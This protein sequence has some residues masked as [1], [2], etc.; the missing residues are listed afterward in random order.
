MTASRPPLSF[1]ADFEPDHGHAVPVFDG[2]MRLTAPN[3]GAFTFHGT[4][5]YLIGER[6]LVIIDPGPEDDTHFLALMNAIAGRPVSHILITHT[7]ADHSPLAKRLKLST[8][9]LT[10][11]YGP[12]VSARRLVEGEIN[13]LDASADKNFMPDVVV[14]DGDILGNDEVRLKAIHTPGHTAN[15]LCFA[16]Q[17]SAVLFS[18]DHVMAWATTIIAPP[19]GSMSHYL[20]SLDKL[21]KQRETIYFPGHGGPVNRPAGFLRGLKS[22]RLMREAAI[23]DQLTS[24]RK[25][26]GEIVGVIYRDTNPRLHGAAALTVLAHMERLIELGM[27]TVEGNAGLAATYAV[28]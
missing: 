9:A 21:R 22:H 2:V 24:G 13:A 14:S 3:G 5:T 11:G 8:G 25:S 23:L 17:N 4:N 1:S 10:A 27:V 12:H 19:D 18:G 20:D 26:I 16:L 15:H 6:T 7:H 28:A